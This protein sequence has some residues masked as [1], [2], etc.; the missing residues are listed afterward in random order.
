MIMD[1]LLEFADDVDVS[2]AA[3][4]AL[5]GDVIDLGVARDI[6]NGE[7]VYLV[8]KT[9]ATE[10]ITG[11]VAGT[12]KFQLAS[13]AQAAIAT[14]GSATVHFDTGTFVTDDEAA[15]D[16]AMNAGGS[17]AFVALPLEGNAYERYLGI[18]VITA[19]TT[20]TEGTINA[21]LTKDP[22]AWQSYADASN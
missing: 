2:A 12:I 9:G 19:T 4:T 16:D 1:E 7:P 22:S 6:G 5:V 11:G 15:N 21:F 3:G 13:D 17:I 14:D 20:T 10:I 18:L 8:I